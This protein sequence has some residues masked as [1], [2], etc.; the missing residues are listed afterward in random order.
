[1]SAQTTRPAGR[2]AQ[3]AL[4]RV[5]NVPMRALLDL[6]FPTPMGRRLMLIHHTGR[7]T[8][9]HYRQ[10]VSYVRDGECLLTP[11][12]GRWTPNLRP[13]EPVRVRLRGKELT[14][15]PEM[16]D[17]PADVER[18]L[19]VMQAANPSLQR[20]VGIPRD[21]DGHLDRPSLNAAIEHGFRIVRWHPDPT[22]VEHGQPDTQ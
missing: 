8:G 19:N 18:L 11:G 4:F 12:G 17:D 15:R 21:R 2:R 9:T 13:D 6:P 22:P 3:A 20:F 1:M 14:A 16:V 7:R 10:P 5:L